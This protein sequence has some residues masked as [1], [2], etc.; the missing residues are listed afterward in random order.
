MI[1]QQSIKERLV[2]AAV[3]VLK[4]CSNRCRKIG[5]CLTQNHSVDMKK[6][7]SAD[8]ALVGKKS[9]SWGNFFPGVPSRYVAW[10]SIVFFFVFKVVKELSSRVGKCGF[11][12]T[13][14]H[15][16]HHLVSLL[17][18]A[19]QTVDPRPKR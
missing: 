16:N 18:Q 10:F 5:H 2:K 8:A 11:F 15:Q 3:K 6:Y 9:F 7:A 4:Y 19:F 14:H 1:Y 17:L 13:V 12:F